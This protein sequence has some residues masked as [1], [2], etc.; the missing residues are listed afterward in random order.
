[1]SLCIYKHSSLLTFSS[2]LSVQEDHCHRCSIKIK[3]PLHI[4]HYISNIYIH[5][6]SYKY[7][8]FLLMKTSHFKLLFFLLL[9]CSFKK[10]KNRNFYP[11]KIKVYLNLTKFQFS[12]LKT[13]RLN[14]TSA[15]LLS[16]LFHLKN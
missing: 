11:L 1:M 13:A 5:I 3:L 14:N 6:Y 12:S 4:L 15:F 2:D 8:S 16:F 7:F 9:N 10:K